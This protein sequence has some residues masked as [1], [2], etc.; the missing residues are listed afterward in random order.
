MNILRN[1]ISVSRIRT[2]ALGI[3][4]QLTEDSVSAPEEGW[5]EVDILV[6]AKFSI[7]SNVEGKNTIYKAQLVFKTCQELWS[8]EHYAYMARTAD[9]ESYLIGRQDRPYPLLSIS[10]S[11]PDNFSDSQLKEVTVTY[12]SALRIPKIA[13]F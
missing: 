6:P 3:V 13:G 12:S 10:D 1:V 9:G 8:N 4:K 11:H 2:S 5:Q 7:I